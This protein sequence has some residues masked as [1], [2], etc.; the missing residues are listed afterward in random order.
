MSLPREQ[1]LL[2]LVGLG[3][4]TPGW[5][6]PPPAEVAGLDLYTC[7]LGLTRQA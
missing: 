3:E 5:P 6:V 1:Q 7:K 2:W 4:G